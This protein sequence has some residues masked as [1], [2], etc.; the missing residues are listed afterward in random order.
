M[1]WICV[2]LLLFDL[3]TSGY[4]PQAARAHYSLPPR[5]QRLPIQKSHTALIAPKKYE[6]RI[7]RYDSKT[8]EAVYY[9]PKPRVVLV[10]VRSGKYALKW[11]GYDGT[12]KTVFYQ[13]PDAIDAVVSASVS[14]TPS[15][16]FLYSYKIDNLSSSGQQ[17]SD[18]A[19]QTF[20]SDARPMKEHPGFVGVMSKNR[21]MKEGTWIFYGSSY[22]GSSVAPGRSVEVRLESSAPPGLVECSVTGGVFGM[23]GVGEEMPQELEN[24]LPGYEIWPR[25]YTVGPMSSLNSLSLTERSKYVNEKLSQFQRLGWMTAE[26]LRWYQL[27]LSANNFDQIHARANEDFKAGKITTEVHDMIEAMKW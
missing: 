3:A 6:K 23:K 19:V 7:L 14:R 24:I 17:L 1:S 9:D 18:F 25:G 27:N 16:R 21:T 11:I 12:E 20:A 22:F 5:L 26:V 4:V 15:G 8:G 10:D 2:F 13:R